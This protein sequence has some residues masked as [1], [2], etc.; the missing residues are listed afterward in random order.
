MVAEPEGGA[1]DLIARGHG[2]QG[3]ERLL[4]GA[5][6]RQLER[7]SQPD[8]LGDDRVDQRV[9]R[10]IAQDAQHVGDVVLARAEMARDE[11]AGGG[12]GVDWGAHGDGSAQA[13]MWAR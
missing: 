2:V 5:R 10:R 1:E 7:T 11:R 9:E 8:A 13:P 4:L 6:R 3:L 12:G